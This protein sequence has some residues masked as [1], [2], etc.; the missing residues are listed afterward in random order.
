MVAMTECSR[1]FRKFGRIWVLIGMLMLVAGTARAQAERRHAEEVRVGST[2]AEVEE[3]LGPA[4]GMVRMGDR[5]IMTFR[6]GQ[7]TFVNGRAVEAQLRTER[8]VWREEIQRAQARSAAQSRQVVQTRDRRV[9]GQ[10]R[11]ATLHQNPYFRQQSAAE[12]LRVW[13]DLARRYPDLDLTREIQAATVA[14]AREERLNR[15]R[16]ARL[17][18][19]ERL[20]QQRR[21]AEA[22]A[23]AEWMAANR[24]V[25]VRRSYRSSGQAIRLDR[26]PLRR[27]PVPEPV[28]NPTFFTPSVTLPASTLPIPEPSRSVNQQPPRR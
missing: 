5:E 11:R 23:E 10:Q 12:R 26:P 4:G 9:E 22:A 28:E 8:E 7:V 2:V 24:R 13:N 14:T 3:I 27:A 17:R 6:R 21:E 18:E 25:A 15:A 19:Q 20:D 1:I 16:I